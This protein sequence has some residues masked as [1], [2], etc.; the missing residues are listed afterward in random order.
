MAALCGNTWLYVFREVDLYKDEEIRWGLW[1]KCLIN[2]DC[3]I[4]KE[5]CTKT[6][7]AVPGN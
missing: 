7:S 2:Y 1:L 5:V 3:G 4:P 6:G